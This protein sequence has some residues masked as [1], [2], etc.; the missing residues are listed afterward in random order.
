MTGEEVPPRSFQE[1]RIGWSFSVDQ[2]DGHCETSAG[3]H[4]TI[5]VQIKNQ[6]MPPD[7]AEEEIE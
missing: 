5:R 4:R 2:V 1:N 6:G 3:R 7:I